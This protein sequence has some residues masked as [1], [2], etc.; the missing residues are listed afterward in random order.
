MAKVA[1]T[2]EGTIKIRERETSER[3]AWVR[4]RTRDRFV[5]LL[6]PSSTVE[7]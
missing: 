7:P 1:W 4:T 2:V 6:D 5:Q 3:G